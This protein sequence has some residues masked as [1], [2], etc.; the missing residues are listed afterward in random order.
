M[1]IQSRKYQSAVN[2]IRCLEEEQVNIQQNQLIPHKHIPKLLFT[3]DNTINQQFTAQYEQ[4]FLKYLNEVIRNNRNKI[5]QC[6]ANLR[7]IL[8]QTD[9]QVLHINTTDEQLLFHY[10]KFLRENDIE[11]H[12]PSPELQHKLRTPVE[13]LPTTAKQNR[14]RTKR[15]RK[16]RPKATKYHKTSENEPT[17]YTRQPI[18]EPVTPT[19]PENHFLSK[20]HKPPLKPD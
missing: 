6:Q 20:G 8:Q 12:I 9:Q 11:Q 5:V 17:S 1:F 3:K 4:M 16:S 18:Q 2:L 14:R 10:Q 19:S 7:I 13:N 15:G